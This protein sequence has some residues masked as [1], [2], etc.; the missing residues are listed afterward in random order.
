MIMS[1]H[2]SNQSLNTVGGAAGAK[3][4][5]SKYYTTQETSKKR[6]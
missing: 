5:R 3:N 1:Q 4:T 2:G 6:Y